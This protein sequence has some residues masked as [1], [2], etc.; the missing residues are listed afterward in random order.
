MSA[1]LDEALLLSEEASEDKEL[2]LAFKRG[3]DGS[4]QAIYTRHLPRVQGICRRMLDHSHDA[5]EAQQETFMRVF[6]SLPSFNGRYRL[7]AWVSRIATNVCLDH[8]RSRGRKPADST[9]QAMFTE[10]SADPADG[11]EDA[12]LAADERQQVR[13]VLARLAP[14]H[15]AALALREFEGMSYADIA[16][17]LGMT[18]PQVKALIHRARKA[19]KK[20]W[21]PGLA[22]FL[23]WRLLARVRKFSNH[24][25]APPQVTDAAVS[26]V[27]FANSCSVALQQ[28]GA[29]MSDKVVSAMTVVVVGAAAVTGVATPG[30]ASAPKVEHRDE[31]Q[32]A[33]RAAPR[34]KPASKKR[35]DTRSRAHASAPAD[36]DGSNSA[37]P[38]P[39]PV[40]SPTPSSSPTPPPPQA[41]PAPGTGGSPDNEP[42]EKP[43]APTLAFARGVVVDSGKPMSNVVTVDCQATRVEQ[44]L[45]SQISYDGQL[46][47]AL[48]TFASGQMALSV[49]KDDQ[50]VGYNGGG[51]LVSKVTS[52]GYMTLVYHGSYGWDG[53]G[54]PSS[55][56]LPY[57]GSFRAELRLDC[58][59]SSVVT[60]NLVFGAN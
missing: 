60:E 38:H 49:T 57:S 41:T 10:L 50:H 56:S 33:A 55:A 24:Y 36:T 4:Y 40:A 8:I 17:A 22:A 54:N 43:T 21:A 35:G 34:A 16:V 25:D 23:P 20:Q 13:A 7:G 30:G 42:A 27:H 47:P 2:V 14:M 45:E 18:E 15:R 52:K 31:T 32:V 44:R 3:E 29:F 46:Y 11:P 39:D 19:F 53:N 37:D 9:D 28:C 48:F 6:T 58:A 1:P 51:E 12:F 5:E 26:T 59:R